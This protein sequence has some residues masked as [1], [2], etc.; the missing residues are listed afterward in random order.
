MWSEE[1]VIACGSPRTHVVSAAAPSMARAHA[2]EGKAVRRRGRSGEAGRG[3]R[4]ETS[5]ETGDKNRGGGF[6]SFEP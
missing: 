2:G 5:A 1:E 4:E 6:E 3:G